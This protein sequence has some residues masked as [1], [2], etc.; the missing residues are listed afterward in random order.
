[1]TK[2]T[3]VAFPYEI[4][5]RR[6]GDVPDLT[7][8]P[9]L[10][11]QELGFLA[12]RGLEEACRDLWKWQTGNPNGACARCRPSQRAAEADLDRAARPSRLRGLV[13]RS[14]LVS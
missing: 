2:A 7:A 3:G 11:Q 14:V 12:R 9:A 13:R 10:A 8:D 5:G 4:V 1:M 6:D